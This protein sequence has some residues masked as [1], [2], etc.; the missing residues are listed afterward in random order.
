MPFLLLLFFALSA[1]AD[2]LDYQSP[3]NPNPYNLG[4]SGLIDFTIQGGTGTGYAF[5]FLFA[6]ADW[7]PG[8][9]AES[10]ISI[11]GFYWSNCQKVP[12]NNVG[13]LLTTN[14]IPPADLTGFI[15]FQFGEDVVLPFSYQLVGV[16]YGP[17]GSADLV[18]FIVFDSNGNKVTNT[19]G[20][21]NGVFSPEPSTLW[22]AIAGLLTWV[23]RPRSGAYRARSLRS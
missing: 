12:C 15:A 1:N 14:Y 10:S 7:Y 5:P 17:S 3:A 20:R 16:G 2:L 6:S 11:D 21:I 4:F 8:G 23:C 18:S 13:S 22:L 19:G 9:Y